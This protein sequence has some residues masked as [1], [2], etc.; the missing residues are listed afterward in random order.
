ME[1]PIPQAKPQLVRLATF[2]VGVRPGRGA[3]C[4]RNEI[5]AVLDQLVGSDG[6]L[7]QRDVVAR[8]NP[9]V[10]SGVAGRSSGPCGGWPTGS[11][12]EI[13]RWSR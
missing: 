13:Q 10:M 5:L 11:G 9:L 8:L 1:V 7:A 3:Q 2:R 4:V 12:R 6:I